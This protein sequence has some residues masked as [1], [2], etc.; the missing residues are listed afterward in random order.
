MPPFKSRV[1]GITT[2]PG[3]RDLPIAFT[4][5]LLLI[6]FF[7]VLTIQD[8]LQSQTLFGAFAGLVM[9]AA[10]VAAR[11]AD[12]QF[13]A[14]LTRRLGLVAAVPAI[15]M[16]IQLLPM[17]VAALSHTIWTNSNEALDQT[18]WGHISADL[19]K[20]LESLAFYL[21]N[22]A[23]ALAA[24]LVARDH[25]RAARLFLVL[26]AVTFLTVLALLAD[27]TFHL[28]AL[29]SEYPPEGLGAASA[30]GLVL[31]L[32]MGALGFERPA[33]PPKK[34][35]RIFLFAAGAGLVICTAGLAAAADTNIVIV[36]VFGAA[37]F[38]SIQLARRLRL[39][40]WTM[41]ILLCTLVVAA[42]MIVAWRFD[43]LRSPSPLLQFATAAPAN[44]IALAQRLLADTGWLGAGAGTYIALLSIYRDFGSALTQ[45]PSTAAGLVVEFG[46]PM[47]LV[48]LGF[49]IWLIIRFYRSALRRGRDSFY[50]AAAA[51]GAVILVGEAFC[52]ASL[53]QAGIAAIGDVLI[54]IGLAQSVSRVDI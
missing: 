5:L 46:L 2:K 37:T 20:T 25:Q 27:R 48:T 35:A 6:A 28:F 45:P 22:I 23:L 34:S 51:S 39:A 49:G 1:S 4:L 54:G 33:T 8:G 43:I 52:D 26:G 12:V 30:L 47:T 10:G 24:L 53:L 40:I 11:A 29:A 36:A 42:T 41:G 15:W 50:A 16:V 14:R 31:S 3:A 38:L 44:S 21:A 7:P 13:A 17:P 32:A 19:G 18:T 9:A